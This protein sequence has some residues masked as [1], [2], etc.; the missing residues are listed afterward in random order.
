MQKTQFFTNTKNILLTIFSEIVRIK[1]T[2]TK[3]TY[4]LKIRPLSEVRGDLDHYQL[5]E[6]VRIIF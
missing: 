5:G 4:Y 3:K 2:H 1:N 6:I